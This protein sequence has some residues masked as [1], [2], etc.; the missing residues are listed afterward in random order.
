MNSPGFNR[1]SELNRGA[2]A[3]SS[4]TSL[5]ILH[6]RASRL[7]IGSQPYLATSGDETEADI[8]RKRERGWGTGRPVPKPGQSEDNRSK[9]HPSLNRGP[10]RSHRK[11]LSGGASE[12]EQK[13]VRKQRTFRAG[14]GSQRLKARVIIQHSTPNLSPIA[15]TRTIEPALS[16]ERSL[17]KS[18]EIRFGVSKKAPA[19][20]SVPKPARAYTIS[21]NMSA[22]AIITQLVDNGCS[23]VTHKL[24]LARCG[25][26]PITGG[27]FGDVY[28]GKLTNGARVA[29][30]CPR[31]FLQSNDNR[32]NMNIAREIYA[33]SKLKHP[34]I[35]PLIGLATFKNQISIVSPWMKNGTLRDYIAKNEDVDRFRLCADISAGLAHL[36]NSGVV[37]GD[38]KGMNVLISANGVP[39]L[40][41][42]G[43]TVL[44]KY[45]IEFTGGSTTALKVSVR[46]T[47]P[48]LFKGEESFT[49]PGDVFALGMVFFEVVTG[50]IPFENKPEHIVGTLIVTG[51]TP[52]IPEELESLDQRQVGLLRQLMHRCW[53]QDPTERPDA[54]QVAQE[55]SDC[56]V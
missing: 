37:H 21:S 6:D 25:E 8:R 45:T 20:R 12:S 36:H 42:F 49:K 51:Q 2:L 18:S 50:E 24:D 55:A 44:K 54:S 7:S 28:Q 13:P 46:W 48:E 52:E 16:A 34:N 9:R 30:K 14:S 23:D 40:T 33:W 22:R 11:T 3:S 53:K 41:D 38:M 39:K 32:N 4:R 56:R 10:G 26:L 43:N 35:L 29:I 19:T 15:D 17:N 27:G 5:D 47:A 1:K 31:L